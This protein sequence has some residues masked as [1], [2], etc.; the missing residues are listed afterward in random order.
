[1]KSRVATIPL[2][3]TMASAI[4]RA[5]GELA[6][7]Q[8]RLSTGKKAANFSDLGTEALRNLS[9]HSMLARQQAHTAVAKGVG[10]T[11]ALYQSNIEAIQTAAED[12]KQTIVTAI[13]TG[14]TAGV[15]EQ[16]Q[17]SFDQFR[18]S[19]NAS[20]S[21]LPLFGG[22]QTGSPFLPQTLADAGTTDPAHA[23][24]DD[25][26]RTTARVAEGID[27]NY[28]IGATAIGGALY[29]AFRTLSQAGSIGEN[30]S[31]T[32]LDALKQAVAQIDTGL[33]SVRTANAE[34]GRRQSQ[35]D[36]LAARGEQRSILLS[37]VIEGNE[38]ADLGQVA[39][40]LAQQ[41]TVLQASYSVF[42]QLSSLSLA[43]YL[44]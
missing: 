30:P 2:Q 23:F 29:T 7:T 24:G 15:Q 3:R 10:T 8:T 44:H 16:I 11:L 37:G 17:T 27:I 1:M 31:S 32:Q 6:I 14:E 20:E 28:G 5:Q 9:A 22:S 19:L 38:D 35:V 33:A 12:M 43:S 26:V 25:D 34:N 13:G 40:D 36:T 21:G 42:A 41:K 18:T 39:I 4:Q